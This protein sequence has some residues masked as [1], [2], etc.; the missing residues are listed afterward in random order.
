MT[1]NIVQLTQSQK[2][3]LSINYIADKYLPRLYFRLCMW[4]QAT[5]N[6]RKPN[7][8]VRAGLYLDVIIGKH[9]LPYKDIQGYGYTFY[10]S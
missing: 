1:L 8:Q 4:L 3:D 5:Y 10:M 6:C 7:K 2:A 9:E